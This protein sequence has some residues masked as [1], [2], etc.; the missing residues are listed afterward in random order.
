MLHDRPCGPVGVLPVES[1]IVGVLT[2]L[3]D[4][5]V[6]LNQKA[7]GADGRVVD[8]IACHGFGELHQQT[9]DFRGRVELAALLARAVCEVLDQILV[10]RA[11][12]VGELEAVVDEDEARL[13]E[14]IQ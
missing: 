7:A 11:K 10:G 4:V 2:L 6:S 13:V 3:L 8:L 1:Q 12:K 14:V 9:H 5:L